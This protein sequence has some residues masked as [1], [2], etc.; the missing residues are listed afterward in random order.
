MPGM[1]VRPHVVHPE[2]IRHDHSIGSKNPAATVIV[3]VIRHHRPTH[4]RR[5]QPLIRLHNAP[6]DLTRQKLGIGRIHTTA[7]TR[8]GRRSRMR[9][10]RR[11]QHPLLWNTRQLRCL[12]LHV[13]QHLSRQHQTVNHHDRQTHRTV[14]Q[15]QRPTHQYVRCSLRCP[16]LHH[17]VNNHRE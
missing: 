10:S 14:V 3:H 7:Q 9:M 4:L 13:I 8:H 1:H 16:L 6:H 12:L 11:D 2:R 5:F 17:P 15:Y